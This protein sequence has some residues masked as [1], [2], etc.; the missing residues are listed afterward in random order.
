MR[1]VGLIEHPSPQEF[2]YGRETSVSTY[3]E[4]YEKV[5]AA[6]YSWSYGGMAAK[7]SENRELFIKLGLSDG[8]G[9]AAIDLGAGSGFQSIPLAELG[10]KVT[11]VDTCRELLA[12][13]SANSAGQS[14]TT[15]NEDIF[16]F[17][18]GFRE[19]PALAVCMGDTISHLESLQAVEKLFATVAGTLMQ[20]GRFIVAFREQSRELTGADRFLTVRA[21][22]NAIFTVFLEYHPEKITVT[23]LVYAKE[24]TD[25]TLKKGTYNKVRLTETFVT[26]ALE[27]AG[28]KIERREMERG[29][30]TLMAM[31]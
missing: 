10:F 14:I 19:K 7:V 13:L 6:H 2:N 3:T 5:L 31:K 28:F 11:A 21:D 26:R 1:V 23:D 20:G 29:M 24:P 8:N 18:A 12:E 4:H 15:A 16:S 17:L 30:V 22:D 27:R 25:W 9:G